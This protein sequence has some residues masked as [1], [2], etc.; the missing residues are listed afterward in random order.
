MQEGIQINGAKFALPQPLSD[1]QSPAVGTITYYKAD[2][3]HLLCARQH[4][5]TPGVLKLPAQAV[6]LLPACTLLSTGSEKLVLG[7]QQGLQ[8]IGM[9]CKLDMQ[10][11]E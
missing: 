9:S 1:S 2:G 10:S 3:E 6:L 8:C 7:L 5:T 4:A 11:P